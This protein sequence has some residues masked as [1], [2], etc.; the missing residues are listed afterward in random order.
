LR[1]RNAGITQ[2]Q[3]LAVSNIPWTTSRLAGLARGSS[4]R[5]FRGSF[6]DELFCVFVTDST[7]TRVLKVMEILPTPRWNDYS[8]HFERRVKPF[9]S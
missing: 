7:L 6:E 2:V 8:M 5:E 1:A 9:S 4:G 3:I